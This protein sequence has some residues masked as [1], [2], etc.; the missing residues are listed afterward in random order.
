M[1]MT[2]F[3]HPVCTTEEADK[4]VA[5]YRRRGVKV[6]RYGEAE[7]LELESNNTPQRWTVEELKEIRIAALADLRA[8]KKLE[9][10]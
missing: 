8:L 5:G 3:Q 6:E 1:K 7:V 4:L 2:W 9:A 10:A